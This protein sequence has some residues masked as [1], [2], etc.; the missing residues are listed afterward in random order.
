MSTVDSWKGV[1]N[2]EQ[3]QYEID[4]KGKGKELKTSSSPHLS[5]SIPPAVT[6]RIRE[7]DQVLSLNRLEEQP[8]SYFTKNYS[9]L[10]ARSYTSG[11]LSSLLDDLKEQSSLRWNLRSLFNVLRVCIS[12]Q[13]KNFKISEIKNGYQIHS[14]TDKLT[15]QSVIGLSQVIHGAID[16]DVKGIFSDHGRWVSIGDVLNKIKILKKKNAA[17]KELMDANNCKLLK[18]KVS[19]Y[20][21]KEEENISKEKIKFLELPYFVKKLPD[22]EKSIVK[23]LQRIYPGSK[24][25][26][27]IDP[28]S[29]ILIYRRFVTTERFFELIK[30]LLL[31]SEGRV[32]AIQKHRLLNLCRTWVSRKYHPDQIKDEKVQTQ[33]QNIVK[34][35]LNSE[36]QIRIDL[37]HDLSSHMMRAPLR[38]RQYKMI[39][40]EYS[41]EKV[42]KELSNENLSDSAEKIASDC[43]EMSRATVLN[44]PLYELLIGEIK[45]TIFYKAS[46][47][48]FERLSNFV[49]VSVLEPA[50]QLKPKKASPLI[51]LRIK[52]WIA[53]A[54]QLLQKGEFSFSLGIVSSLSN[55]G[56]SRLISE[57]EKW[58]PMV[59]T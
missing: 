46:I 50:D 11:S 40:G 55:P 45:D 20:K 38:V 39:D 37:A 24:S 41:L 12:N 33:I 35:G 31:E 16:L 54:D 28:V 53:V 22:N 48:R 4:P 52:L 7:V 5:R 10:S 42:L 8:A 36:D 56:I 51:Q 49:R 15:P 1:F 44:I 47:E 2:Q 23:L 13:E 34:V 6:V 27:C 57:D 3:F 25:E 43:Y 14:T 30:L 19:R 17:F 9:T 58:N 59:S 21:G 29:L 26:E 32:P 18:K